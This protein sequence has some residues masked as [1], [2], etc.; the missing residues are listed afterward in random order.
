MSKEEKYKGVYLSIKISAKTN[1]LLSEAAK[2][3]GR[4]KLQEALIRL[5]DHLDR[6]ESISK[7]GHVLERGII[8]SAY[9]PISKED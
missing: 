7:V 3:S 1:K 6:I 2:Q 9:L 8:S 4:K 5:E